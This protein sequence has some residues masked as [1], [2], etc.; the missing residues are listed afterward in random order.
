VEVL[1]G[2]AVGELVILVGDLVG[3]AVSI[4]GDMDLVGVP[5]GATEVGAYV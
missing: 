4:V 3:D 2:D 1:V 5:V